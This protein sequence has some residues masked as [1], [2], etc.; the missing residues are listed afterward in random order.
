MAKKSK[1]EATHLVLSCIDH[2]CTDD[3]VSV[4]KRIIPGDDAW[5]RY[6]HIALPGASL[7]VVQREYLSWSTAFWEQLG[8][9]LQLHPFVKTVVIVDHLHCGAY[10]L[11]YKSVSGK[12]YDGTSSAAHEDITARL[13]TQFARKH[14]ELAVERWVL[15]PRDARKLNW[16]ARSLDSEKTFACRRH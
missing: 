5:D 3:L 11:L 4:M 2:R 13:K 14:P 10:G 1:V 7:G 9:A 8:A 15:E 6:D 12:D 16:C